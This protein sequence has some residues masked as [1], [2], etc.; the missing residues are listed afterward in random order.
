MKY[1]NHPTD[2][3]KT[4]ELKKNVEFEEVKLKHIDNKQ[5]TLTSKIKGRFSVNE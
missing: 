1:I 4:N 5:K 2:W 3:M